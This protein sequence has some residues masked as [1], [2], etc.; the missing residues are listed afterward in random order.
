MSGTRYTEEQKD[1]VF[2]LYVRLGTLEKV[3]RYL[4]DNESEMGFSS[5]SDTTLGKWKRQYGW[6]EQKADIDRLKDRKVG[7][8]TAEALAEKSAEVNRVVAGIAEVGIQIFQNRLRPVFNKLKADPNYIITDKDLK[9]AGIGGS[10]DDLKKFFEI[11]RLA[12]GEPTEI[13]AV[14]DARVREEVTVTGEAVRQA[15][16]EFFA[17]RPSKEQEEFLDELERQLQLRDLVPGDSE[18]KG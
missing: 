1:Q 8:K 18:G 3:R 5:M 2:Q 13:Q 6:E 9:D 17:D 14:V 12:V 15:I 4:I 7:E 10:V 16:S 11:Y